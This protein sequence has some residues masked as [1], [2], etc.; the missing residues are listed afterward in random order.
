MLPV[1]SLFF[2]V[3]K[4]KGRYLFLL[5][6]LIY[7][8]S[9][10][11]KAPVLL[12]GFPIIVY[13]V[14]FKKYKFILFYLSSTILAFMMIHFNLN[15]YLSHKTKF[16]SSAEASIGVEPK[17]HDKW[18]MLKF[19]K[20]SGWRDASFY[21]DD[22]QVSLNN[23]NFYNSN[24]ALYAFY[25]DSFNLGRNFFATEFSL[26]V[27]DDFSCNDYSTLF[28]MGGVSGWSGVF[29]IL[30]KCDQKK[31]I[32]L[33]F[34]LIDGSGNEGFGFK[35]QYLNRG[36]E[37]KI[38]FER[39]EDH[40]K[41]SVNGSVD[42]IPS[43]IFNLTVPQGIK[44][45]IQFGAQF[46]GGSRSQGEGLLR[47]IHINTF[48][49][50]I[51]NEN[52]SKNI[53]IDYEKIF[54]ESKISVSDE[55][56]VTP[57]LLISGNIGNLIDRFLFVPG[58]TGAIWIDL[59]PEKIPYGLG[60]GYKPIAVIIDCKFINFPVVIHQYVEV[61]MWENGIKGTMNSAEIFNGYANF[62][63]WGAFIVGVVMACW[64]FIISIVFKNY[65]IFG[66][67]SMA[68][69]IIMQSSVGLPVSLVSGGWLFSVAL[70]LFLRR[71]L[72]LEKLKD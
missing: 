29:Q 55:F 63:I 11:Q 35:S 67:A 15:G 37:N 44:K 56:T 22:N 61:E 23:Q 40:A 62:G 5:L 65:Q 3:V 31:K 50:E 41:I 66:F 4:S 8:G 43:K 6:S 12:I 10:I 17:I 49:L 46:G 58:R 69:F 34:A 14:I 26:M 45:I 48:S 16:V 36:Q 24:K 38:Y 13:L 7:V 30:L 51:I 21:K 18:Y 33:E 54:E 68:P 64:I 1:L 72:P 59:I 25:D 27:E 52:N 47:G 70:F 2:L 42:K 39:L 53:I 20:G 57:Y 71:Y 32:Y 9:F 19:D 28:Y 60:C